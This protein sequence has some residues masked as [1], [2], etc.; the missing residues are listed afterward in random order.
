M[1]DSSVQV[2]AEVRRNVEEQVDV[3]RDLRAWEAYSMETSDELIKLLA[4][5]RRSNKSP[6]DEKIVSESSIF[7]H[8]AEMPSGLRKKS[9]EWPIHYFEWNT[10]GTIYSR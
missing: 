2:Q 5:Q 9:K 10:A 1:N 4:H 6:P 3:L 8:C 7:S